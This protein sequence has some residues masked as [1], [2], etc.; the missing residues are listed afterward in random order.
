MVFDEVADFSVVKPAT[1]EVPKA[2]GTDVGDKDGD[3]H[4]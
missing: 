2:V 4:V 1:R 3:N